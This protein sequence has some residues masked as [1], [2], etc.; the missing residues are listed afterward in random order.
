MELR[1]KNVLMLLVPSSILSFTYF[2]WWQKRIKAPEKED[3]TLKPEVVE[4]PIVTFKDIEEELVEEILDNAD[5]FDDSLSLHEFNH[6]SVKRKRE[7]SSCDAD[8]AYV[9]DFSSDNVSITGS[10]TNSNKTTSNPDTTNACDYI[11]PDEVIEAPV[12]EE[13]IAPEVSESVESAP[14]NNFRDWFSPAPVIIT[15]DENHNKPA[16]EDKIS[17]EVC[18][19]VE[20]APDNNFQDWFNSGYESDKEEKD[21]IE[22]H[23]GSQPVSDFEADT[24]NQTVKD[25]V[26]GVAIE[27]LSIVLER[28]YN[29][30]K[31][32]NLKK[33][34]KVKSTPKK[35]PRSPKKSP[36][37][38]KTPKSADSRFPPKSPKHKKTP[39][40]KDREMEK[41][42]RN[43][44]EKVESP[45]DGSD[46]EVFP[47]YPN[48]FVVM[49]YTVAEDLC[50]KIIGKHGKAVKDINEKTGAF[51]C[52][53]AEKVG[54][55]CVLSIAGLYCQVQDAEKALMTKH[56]NALKRHVS[57]W[58]ANNEV[59]NSILP[60]DD[61]VSVIVTAVINAGNL[62]V[63]VFNSDVDSNLIQLQ[64][65]LDIAY[66]QPPQRLMYHESRKPT[67]GEICISFIDNMWCRVRVVEHSSE[68]Q[69]VVVFVDYGGSV[70]IDWHL[71]YKIRDP[72]LELPAQAIQCYITDSYP[73]PN[74]ADY[75][76]SANLT[77]NQMIEGKVLHAYVHGSCNDIPCVEL[78]YTNEETNEDVSV[79]GNLVNWGLVSAYAPIIIDDSQMI[80]VN[81][82]VPQEVSPAP[83]TVEQ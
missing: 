41:P 62:F 31:A 43:E 7:H 1:L 69:V 63:Q 18:Q 53:E 16:C 81:A 29:E 42:W 66:N 73:L 74:Q 60:S 32:K 80:E 71:L 28:E 13:I 55:K 50:G 27:N 33:T 4:E 47:L 12:Y 46:S 34:E 78:F 8:S 23:W 82:V 58:P 2:W 5:T 22:I 36:R 56:K 39:K 19:N 37:T 49:E 68:S 83:L 30:R 35:S 64:K 57:Q 10:D 15:E 77:L 11:Q 61:Y 6:G 40:R 9:E 45:E 3:K 79:N 26:G 24:E 70:V 21:R 25:Y 54:P 17:S 59:Q 75:S 48:D 76:Y 44:P 72:F 51:V 20:S 67:I 52:I 38:P 14:S 65:D